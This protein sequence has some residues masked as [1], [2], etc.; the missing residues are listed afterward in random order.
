MLVKQPLTFFTGLES[1]DNT[2]SKYQRKRKKLDEKQ[3]NNNSG[4]SPEGQEMLKV[5]SKRR[6]TMKILPVFYLLNSPSIMRSDGKSESIS[7]RKAGRQ[8]LRQV[9]RLAKFSQKHS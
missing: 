8:H 3:I 5:S 6:K 7:A 1:T 2:M 4:L 9:T